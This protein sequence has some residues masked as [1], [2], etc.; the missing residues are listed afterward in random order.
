MFAG[1][2]KYFQPS[3]LSLIVLL[4]SLLLL[5]GSGQD[6]L[7]NHEPDLEHHHDC[8]AHQLYLLFSSILIFYCIFYFILS[9]LV[10]LKLILYE[11]DHSYFYKNHYSRAPPFQIPENFYLNPLKNRIL[12]FQNLKGINPV[13]IIRE[14]LLLLRFLLERIKLR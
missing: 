1:I 3:N 2:R 11:P 7:H 9:I 12:N 10:A 8:P 13:S 4:V 14:N 6:L 5:L